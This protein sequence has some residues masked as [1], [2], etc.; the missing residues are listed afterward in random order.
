MNNLKQ[1]A[2]NLCLKD[3]A[4]FVNFFVGANKQLVNMLCNLDTD[5]ET[6]FVYIWGKHGA[7]KSH[8]LSALCQLFGEHDHIA[9]Y[10]PLEEAAQLDPKI[11]ED[12]EKLDLLCIDD[13]NL[14]AGNVTWEERFFHCFNKIVEYGK[15]IVI[16]A[17]VAPLA[18]PLVLPDLKSRM[19]SGLIFEV[20]VLSDVEKTEGLKLRAK[21]RGLEL[22]DVVAQFLLHHYARDTKSLFATLDQLDKA[23]LAAQ[24]KLTIPFVKNVLR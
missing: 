10:L 5:N 19:T 13:L 2:L 3:A 15:Q 24:R 7:G 16:T 12:L 8:L 6:H 20:Q 14:I 4:T 1:L 9:A 22:N 21:L 11:L 18:L 17:N 23:A